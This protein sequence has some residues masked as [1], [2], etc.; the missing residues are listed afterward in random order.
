MLLQEDTVMSNRVLN[1]AEC[2]MCDGTC[3]EDPESEEVDLDD[4]GGEE[5]EEEEVE[6]AFKQADDP[7]GSFDPDAPEA[8]AKRENERHKDTEAVVA[9][10]KGSGLPTDF[11]G[12][13]LEDLSRKQLIAFAEGLEAAA[14]EIKTKTQ[15][16]FASAMKPI[17]ALSPEALMLQDAPGK[18][19]SVSS[20]AALAAAVDKKKPV[21]DAAFTKKRLLLAITN[22]VDPF[23][24]AR[25]RLNALAQDALASAKILRAKAS[26]V[27]ESV[28]EP[29]EEARQFFSKELAAILGAK[30]EGNNVVVTGASKEEVSKKI[31]AA[32]KSLIQKNSTANTAYGW[33]HQPGAGT[34][35]VILTPH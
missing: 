13:P 28:E 18:P 23:E 24:E 10:N 31:S 8:A 2:A 34:Y 22:I 16:S 15:G 21:I 17:Y 35:T 29:V 30:V 11:M 1:L 9:K 32:Y 5:D 4:V 27:Q 12:I 6:E 14:R 7:P 19:R 33:K 3:G 26:K 25:D 20:D